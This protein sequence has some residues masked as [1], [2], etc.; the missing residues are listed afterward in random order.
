MQ[1]KTKR[2]KTKTENS[3]PCTQSPK[4]QDRKQLSRPLTLRLSARLRLRVR[5]FLLSLRFTNLIQS[6]TNLGQSFPAVC[7]SAASPLLSYFNG[8]I[9]GDDARWRNRTRLIARPS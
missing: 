3:G 2:R 9:N 6:C 7:P 5:A 1:S 8:D 4:S